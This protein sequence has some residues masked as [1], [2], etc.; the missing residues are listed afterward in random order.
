M[1]S[2]PILIPGNISKKKSQSVYANEADVLNI[3]LFGIK[4]AKEWGTKTRVKT[5]T[6]EIMSMLPN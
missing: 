5:A 4:T 1:P 2:K 6:S 3:A